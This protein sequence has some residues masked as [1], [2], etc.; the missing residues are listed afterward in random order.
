MPWLGHAIHGVSQ[1]FLILVLSNILWYAAFTD[2]ILAASSESFR[3]TQKFRCRGTL[4]LS[5]RVV[6]AKWNGTLP[7]GTFGTVIGTTFDEEIGE[8]LVELVTEIPLLGK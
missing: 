4:H 8:Q 7:F 1:E 3:S 2:H 5:Q 6:Y